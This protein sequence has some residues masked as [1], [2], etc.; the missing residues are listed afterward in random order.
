LAAPVRVYFEL[1]TRCNAACHYC[2]NRS[3]TVRSDELTPGESLSF[4][5]FLWQDGL[6]IDLTN[7]VDDP[8][9][10]GFGL[11]QAYDINDNGLIVGVSGYQIEP[12]LMTPVPEPSSCMMLGM[13]IGILGCAWFVVNRQL[14]RP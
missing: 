10:R 9:F 8:T 3:G 13:G 2:L 5:P 6:S 14:H 7:V 1:T 4:H 12:F 11:W